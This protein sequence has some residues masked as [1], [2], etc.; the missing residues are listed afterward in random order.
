MEEVLS[1]IKIVSEETN[2]LTKIFVTIQSFVR[3]FLKLIEEQNREIGSVS[4]QSAKIA[5]RFD[6]VS[7]TIKGLNQSVRSTSDSITDLAN[8]AQV[9]S[10]VANQLD[11]R[12]KF[13][14]V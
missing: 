7:E 1:G 2:S 11:S 9:L 4:D 8:S 13:F 5:K 14:I 3:D 12:M 6:Q 10:E